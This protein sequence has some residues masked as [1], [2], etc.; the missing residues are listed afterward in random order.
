MDLRRL[1][2]V[3]PAAVGA[4]VAA[5]YAA[6]AMLYRAFVSH[7]GVF[8]PDLL[9]AAGA[10]GWALYVRGRVTP[11]ARPQDA[12]GRALRPAQQP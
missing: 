6:S 11:L 9:V 7:E 12:E 1:L 5:A 10:A 4:A 3:E 2:Q 8:D